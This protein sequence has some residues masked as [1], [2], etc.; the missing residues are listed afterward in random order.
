MPM[1]FCDCKMCCGCTRF[2]HAKGTSNQD[3][4]VADGKPRPAFQKAFETDGCAH[5][6]KPEF[7]FGRSIPDDGLAAH[8]IAYPCCCV[9]YF[10][11]C[12]TFEKTCSN[13]NAQTRMD[14]NTKSSTNKS[15]GFWGCWN[16]CRKWSNMEFVC[17]P[18]CYQ[19]DLTDRKGKCS[20]QKD[21]NGLICNCCKCCLCFPCC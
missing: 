18:C 7:K 3:D 10:C 16:P 20:N 15:I 8:V 2:V 4:S 11:G 13:C 14:D 12:V 1:T 9:N 19:A 6:G 17:K 5:C 21:A